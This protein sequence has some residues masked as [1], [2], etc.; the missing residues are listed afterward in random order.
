MRFKLKYHERDCEI[1]RFGNWL[2]YKTKDYGGLWVY[3][4]AN[5]SADP[6]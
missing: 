1:W 4:K 3:A 5:P 2:Y 6:S